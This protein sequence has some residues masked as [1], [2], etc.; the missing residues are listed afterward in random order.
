MKEFTVAEK[1][2]GI[3]FIKYLGKILSGANTSFIYKMLRK[4]NILL[5]DKKASGNEVLKAEDNIKLYFSDETYDKFS[6]KPSEEKDFHNTVAK[7]SMPPIVYEDKNIIILNKPVGMLSQKSRDSDISLNE[8]CLSYLIE[9][10]EVTEE[11][12]RLYKP[13]VINR[14]DRNTTGLMIFAK[15]YVAANILSKALKE[16][17]IHKYYK[18]V[19]VGTLRDETVLKGELKKDNETNKVT[20][21]EY[22][23]DNPSETSI[24]TKINPIRSNDKYSL[25]EVLLI[26]GKT[27]QIRA[28]L[29]YIGHPIVGDHKYGNS[30]I[31]KEVSRKYGINSQ[32]LVSY[33]IEMPKL[34]DELFE[35]SEKTFEIDIPKEFEELV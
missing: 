5:N 14:L 31:N 29:A 22:N 16:R 9:K 1:D 18:C 10:K 35:I 32:L 33:K 3:K 24:Y 25:L 34:P 30:T 12:I 7:G 21:T 20:V 15:T 13:S 17:S 26:T 11:S 6:Q 28:H 2:N 4:K 23:E 8:I 27:H 19:V